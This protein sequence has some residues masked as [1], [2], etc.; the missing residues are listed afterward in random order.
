MPTHTDQL[1]MKDTVQSF[2]IALGSAS[3]ALLGK[4]LIDVITRRQERQQHVAYLAVRVVYELDRFT[5]ACFDIATDSGP[6]L[7][8]Y[9][10]Y[11]PLPAPP[12][13]PQDLPV[14]WKAIDVK[15]TYE[16]F[17]L[18]SDQAAV[19]DQVHNR[20]GGKATTSTTPPSCAR[21]ATPPSVSKLQTWH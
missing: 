16:V 17:N 4:W 6:S 5:R 7:E 3:F 8:T 19:E 10:T 12:F 21:G 9:Q 2:L 15:M 18:P 14:D 1:L 20:F 11:K 13:A